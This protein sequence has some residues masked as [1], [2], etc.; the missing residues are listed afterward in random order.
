MANN[1][2]IMCIKRINSLYEKLTPA[3]KLIANY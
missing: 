3:E 1:D 2:E